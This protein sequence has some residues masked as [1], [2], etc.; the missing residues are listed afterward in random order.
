MRMAVVA[1]ALLG[2][3]ASP[4]ESR[5]SAAELVF[6]EHVS[7]VTMLDRRVLRDHTVA[8]RGK[9]IESVTPSRSAVVPAGARRIDGRARYLMPGLVDMHA[10][11]AEQPSQPRQAIEDEML[12][13]LSHGVTAVRNPAGSVTHLRIRDELDTGTML[14]PRAFVA[15]PILESQPSFPGL[16]NSLGSRFVQ[17]TDARSA[18]AEIRR[19]RS[20]G[21]DFVKIYN[22][23]DP[24]ILAAVM[25]TAGEVGLP[26]IGHVPLQS[27]LQGAFDFKQASIEHLRGYDLLLSPDP[28]S[29]DPAVRFAGWPAAADDSIDE[30]VAGTVEA[31][32]WNVPTLLVAVA[33]VDSAEVRRLGREYPY[34]PPHLQGQFDRSMFASIYSEDIAQ[35]VHAG[36]PKQCEFVRRL[37]RAG[38]RVMAGTDGLVPG[39]ALLGELRAFRRC[40]L[41]V[42]ETLQTAT[43]H[44]GEWLSK[45]V[46]R[47]PRIGTVQAGAAGDLVLLDHN[48]L[49]TLDTLEKPRGVM[50]NGEWLSREALVAQLE[51]MRARSNEAMAAKSAAHQPAAVH[52]TAEPLSADSERVQAMVRRVEADMVPLPAGTFPMGDP[53]GDG[54]VD[55]RPVH[56]VHVPAFRMARFEVTFEQYDLFTS[57]TCRQP[58]EDN[59]WGR[60]DRPIINVTWPEAEAFIDWLSGVSGIRYRLPT[61]AEWEYAARAGTT[62]AYYWGDEYSPD[63]A[64]GDGIAGRDQYEFTAPVGQFPPNAWGL[65]D[66]SG[67][68]WEYTADCYSKD[69]DLTPTDGSAWLAPGCNNRVVRGGAWDDGRMS[70]RASPRFRF[71]AS[72]RMDD[73]GFRVA[74]DAQPRCVP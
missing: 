27:G 64:N 46:P 31:G 38:G 11:F 36:L 25:R 21:Y 66:T 1:L 18:A 2:I 40:G 62:T 44:P 43:V 74:T 9:M 59:G 6:I 53:V 71:G 20:L 3:T 30:L 28:S 52:C 7:V 13:Y 10:H 65:F 33:S 19:Q 35:L 73:I 32:A 42:F 47:A 68:V 16:M 67:N 26:V 37:V 50:I 70:L 24:E 15:G 14:G 57:A 54:D 45:Y 5:A 41:S 48:P 12:L 72:S 55:E 22:R 49:E 34:L 17:L 4:P 58:V 69:Y 23:I 60:A 29:T 61:E 39:A 56:D 51:H 8:I 63:Q